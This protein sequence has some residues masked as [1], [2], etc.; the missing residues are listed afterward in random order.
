MPASRVTVNTWAVTDADGHKLRR[1]IVAVLH[2][3]EGGGSVD[4]LLIAKQAEATTDATTGIATFQLYSNDD[5]DQAG[6][7]YSFT[8][9][10]VD[11]TVVRRYEIPAGA[12]VDLP[13]LT[14]VEPV[15]FSGYVPNPASGSDGDVL[16]VASDGTYQ[17][18]SVDGASVESGSGAELFKSASTVAAWEA[19]ASALGVQ[20]GLRDG[21]S[22][23]LPYLVTDTGA[24]MPGVLDNAASVLAAIGAQALSTQP[25]SRYWRGSPLGAKWTIHGDPGSSTDRFYEINYPGSDVFAGGKVTRVVGCVL[26]MEDDNYFEFLTQFRNPGST[27]EQDNIEDAVERNGNR[28]SAFMERCHTDTPAP[29]EAG[30]DATTRLSIASG[31]GAKDANYLIKPGEVFDLLFVDYPGTG[32]RKAIYARHGGAGSADLTLT[33]DGEDIGWVLVAEKTGSGTKV[34]ANPGLSFMVGLGNRGIFL[35]GRMQAW[36]GLSGTTLGTP[37]FD[38]NPAD[39]TVGS[40]NI[41]DGVSGTWVNNFS[42]VIDLTLDGWSLGGS[43]SVADGA[44]TTAKLA[45]DAVTAAKIAADAV[46]SSEIAAGAVGSSELADGGVTLAKM[47]DVA[48]A[49]I[50]GRTTAGTGVPEALTAAQARSVLGLVVGTDVQAYDAGLAAIASLTSAADKLPY[51]TGSGTA[52]LADLTSFARSLLDDADAAAARATLG[53]PYLHSVCIEPATQKPNTF[54]TW[55]PTTAAVQGSGYAAGATT[56]GGETW[57]Y[58]GLPLKAGTWAL[59]LVI[60]KTSSSG[61]ITCSLGGSSVGTADGY[62]GSNTGDQRITV[63]SSITVAADGQYDLVLTNPTAN[64]SAGGYGWTIQVIDLR[65]TG[66]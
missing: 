7:F 24:T 52:A 6:S 38:F 65:R 16:K 8:V 25:A 11:P 55:T 43:G 28:I 29:V 63:S 19:T 21:F 31:N 62:A 57:T 22:S 4:G 1:R 20:P 30:E 15:G 32:W 60:R 37:V 54:T 58:A 12:E 59:D 5:I 13:D 33:I 34:I 17:L 56:I 46:G 39:A 14:E 23:V 66:A 48:T 53:I 2:A 44:I 51:F 40:G 18:G 27:P 47:A 10:D 42:E 3:G 41:T 9:C 35:C 36:A 50:L 49:R 64:A 26:S 61:I 45:A